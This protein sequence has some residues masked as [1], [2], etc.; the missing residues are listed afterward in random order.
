MSYEFDFN[1]EKNKQLKQS[2]N[3]SFE[4]VIFSIFN[5]QILDIVEHH[6]KEQYGHQKMF[7]VD[8]DNYGYLVPY[9]VQDDG[10]IF[11]K[12]IFPSRKATKIYLGDKE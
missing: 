2:R 7:I 9:V 4:E 12:T 3:I 10:K 1:P 6:N 8:I 11:L 5:G